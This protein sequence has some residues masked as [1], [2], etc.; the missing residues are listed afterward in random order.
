[1]PDQK[2]VLIEQLKFT[3]RIIN[4]VTKLMEDLYL[5]QNRIIKELSKVENNI[6]P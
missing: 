2:E 4:H 5:E 1:M 3:N 6:E